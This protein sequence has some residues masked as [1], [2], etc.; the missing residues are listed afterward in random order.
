M[1][2]VS[3][4]SFLI[5]GGTSGLGRALVATLSK[6]GANVATFAR[7]AAAV[8]KLKKEFSNVHVFQADVSKK[9]HI[10]MIAAAAFETLGGVDVLIN[11][12]SSLGPTPLRLLLDTDC[13]D[14]EEVLQTNLLGPFRLVKA[15]AASM[16]TQGSGL[17]VNVSSDAAINGYAKWGAYSASKAALDHLTRVF[18]AEL[19]EH[20]LFSVAVDP[21][22]MNTP[23]HLAAIPDADVTA[24]KD[25]KVAADQLVRWIE[26]GD[27]TNERIK[28]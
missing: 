16:I 17:V 21:G 4:L 8:A 11:N 15:I 7:S 24:L 6:R 14:F 19:R 3:R 1:K 9:E 27:F 2:P 22:D 12:A 28:L 26:T 5:T 25:P 20:G 23:M 18:N 10:Q 13:E